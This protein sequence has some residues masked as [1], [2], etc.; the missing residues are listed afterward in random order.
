MQ[1][2]TESIPAALYAPVSSDRQDVDLSVVAQFWA[3]RDYAGRNGY[4]G[5]RSLCEAGTVG[6]SMD[7]RTPS[8]YGQVR[9]ADGCNEHPVLVPKLPADR[10]VRRIS[11]MAL[12]APQNPSPLS[13]PLPQCPRGIKQ[14]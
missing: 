10:V 3:L 1:Q 9:V 4:G 8:G 14:R 13:A 12:A 6:F 11:G 7:S 5:A 2:P